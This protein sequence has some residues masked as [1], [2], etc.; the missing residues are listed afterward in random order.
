MGEKCKLHARLANGW[1]LIET[2]ER[3]KYFLERLDR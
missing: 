2:K 3:L 1:R